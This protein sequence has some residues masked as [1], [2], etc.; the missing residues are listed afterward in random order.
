MS[1]SVRP[2]N[3]LILG[4]DGTDNLIDQIIP[5]IGTIDI[6]TYRAGD[7]SNVLSFGYAPQ[8]SGRLGIFAA[9]KD[10]S[11]RAVIMLLPQGRPDGV[12]ICITQGFA[13]A[14]DRLNPLGWSNPLSVPFVNFALLKHVINRYGPQML[15]SGRNLALMYILRAGG[16]NELGPFARDGAF[17]RFTLGE[18]AGLTNNAF[19][20][21]TCEAFTFSSGIYDFNTFLSAVSGSVNIRA[22]YSIDPSHSVAAATPSGGRRKQYASGTAGPLLPGFEHLPLARWVN[23][24]EFSTSTRIGRFE[25]LHN[26]CMPLYTLNLGL[27]TP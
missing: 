9:E 1:Q 5:A 15:A 24:D 10:G 2:I 23:E 4:M 19:S 6:A 21:D 7:S 16:A 3:Q 25:Y 22:T 17:L 8:T 27:R 13:Q 18:I 11:E 14:A 26:R 20:F 12:L